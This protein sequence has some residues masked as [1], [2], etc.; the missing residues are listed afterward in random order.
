MQITYHGG[1]GN[2][3]VL[4]QIAAVNGPQLG[5]V[6]K[7]PDGN[8][9]IGATGLPNTSYNIEATQNLAPP[10]S[11][12]VIGSTLSDAQGHLQFTDVNATNYPIRFYRFVLP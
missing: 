5:G 11:W 1:D 9:Q 7:L 3:V 8:I 12:A 6:E 2:D 4:M 10:A